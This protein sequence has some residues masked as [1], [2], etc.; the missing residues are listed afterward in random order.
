MTIAVS[1]PMIG[2]TTI[3]IMGPMSEKVPMLLKYMAINAKVTT[4]PTKKPP[5]AHPIPARMLRTMFFL[6]FFDQ[7][8]NPFSI[9]FEK[10]DN[11]NTDLYHWKRILTTF[12][13]KLL[14]DLLTHTA[15]CFADRAEGETPLAR[16]SRQK[17]DMSALKARVHKR[18][19]NH[20]PHPRGC[21]R[22]QRRG[23][24]SIW[25]PTGVLREGAGAV[26]K[27]VET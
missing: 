10:L 8:Q 11:F 27:P 16:V 12:P 7:M 25:S 5:I 23:S 3:A 24:L 15:Q 2:D 9:S 4:V 17:P 18:P 1:T 22:W 21:Y 20:D 26:V 14:R 6:L 19:I 13:L